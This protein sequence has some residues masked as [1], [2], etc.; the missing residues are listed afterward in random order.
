[1]ERLGHG[2]GVA[3]M[4]FSEF[5]WRVPENSNL[6]TDHGAANLMFLAGKPLQG[7]HYGEPPSLTNLAE[8]DNFGATVDFRRVYATMIDGWL[9]SGRAAAVLKGDFDPLPLFGLDAVA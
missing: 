9:N 5:G 3:G 7:G 2:D 6:G 8:G 4:V 1:M